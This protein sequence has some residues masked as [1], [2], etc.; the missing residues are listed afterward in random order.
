MSTLHFKF[1]HGTPVSVRRGV[2]SALD[3]VGALDV[4]LLFADDRDEELVTLYVVDFDQ[5]STGKLLLKVLRASDA[6][7][8]VEEPATRKLIV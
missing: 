3:E 4:R 1:Q 6:V 5:P 7:E 2:I 8:F